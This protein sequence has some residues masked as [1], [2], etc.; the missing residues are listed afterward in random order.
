ML[1][2]LMANHLSGSEANKLLSG[3]RRRGVCCVGRGVPYFEGSCYVK[4]VGCVSTGECRDGQ[5]L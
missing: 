5:L 2:G 4:R 3:G 1:L